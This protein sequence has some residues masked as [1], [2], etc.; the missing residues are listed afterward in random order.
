MVHRC[1]SVGQQFKS[2]LI[3][4]LYGIKRYSRYKLV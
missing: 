4:P 3:K 1:T 2:H